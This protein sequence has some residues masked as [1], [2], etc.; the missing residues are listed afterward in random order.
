M[1]ELTFYDF[2]SL[3]NKTAKRNGERVGCAMVQARRS[4]TSY[5]GDR[6]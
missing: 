1:S 2:V 6:G 4:P 3:P 5:R